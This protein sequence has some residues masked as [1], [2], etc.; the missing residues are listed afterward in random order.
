MIDL[1]E[2]TEDVEETLKNMDEEQKKDFEQ[3]IDVENLTLL[4]AWR[5]VDRQLFAKIVWLAVKAYGG[6]F[7]PKEEMLPS[8]IENEK[9]VEIIKKEEDLKKSQEE[10]LE[11]KN[12]IELCEEKIN[13]IENSLQE[14]NSLLNN[15]I[16]NKSQA[17]NDI[18]DLGKMKVKLEEVKKL[19]ED[20]LKE[21][22]GE[23]GKCSS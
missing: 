13:S 4:N 12:K 17:E 9:E 2:T 23:S 11:L 22:K 7:T 15:A 3:S 18:I 6:R 19:H 20:K 5:K 16:K 8:F 10:L 21:I 14:K 1:K